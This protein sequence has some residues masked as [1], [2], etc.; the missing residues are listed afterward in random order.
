MVAAAVAGKEHAARGRLCQ[1]GRVRVGVR[2]KQLLA[3][4]V[5]PGADNYDKSNY[6]VG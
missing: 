3:R 2:E 6:E 5:Q 4:T 1:Q